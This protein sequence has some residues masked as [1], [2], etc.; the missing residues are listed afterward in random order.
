MDTM[1]KAGKN[2]DQINAAVEIVSKEGIWQRMS[3]GQAKIDK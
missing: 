1:L 3:K 2:N